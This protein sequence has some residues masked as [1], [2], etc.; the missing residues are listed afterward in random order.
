MIR[1]VVIE[2]AIC[3]QLGLGETRIAAEPLPIGRIGGGIGSTCHGLAASLLDRGAHGERVAARCRLVHGAGGTV[4]VVVSTAYG[5]PYE[6]D[7]PTERVL[8]VAGEAIAAQPHGVVDAVM[9]VT[10]QG[11]VISDKYSLPAL[12]RDNLEVMLS[13]VLDATLL[14]QTSRASC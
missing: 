11:E 10:E 4:D 6:G 2:I 3:R 12:A 8:W 5:C 1:R 7:V 13:A 14:H 9:K